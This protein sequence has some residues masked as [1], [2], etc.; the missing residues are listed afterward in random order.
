MGIG[1]L[2]V[3]IETTYLAACDGCAQWIFTDADFFV[4]DVIGK[5]VPTSRHRTNKDGDGVRLWQ[6]GQEF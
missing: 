3:K 2:P 1:D 6:R 4:D 5:V